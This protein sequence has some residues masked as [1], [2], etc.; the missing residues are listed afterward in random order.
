[1]D[2]E[3]YQNHHRHHRHHHHHHRHDLGIERN[4]TRTA[5]SCVT[6]M[7]TAKLNSIMIHNDNND[8]VCETREDKL[9][10]QQQPETTFS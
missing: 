3:D 5:F 2:I 8:D 6:T 9:C 4:V 1:M 7:A 10:E